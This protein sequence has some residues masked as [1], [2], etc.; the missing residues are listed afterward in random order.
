MICISGPKS[1]ALL[2]YVPDSEYEVIQPK[3]LQAS[4]WMG[5]EAG[6]SAASSDTKALAGFSSA[7]GVG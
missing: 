4:I 7:A 5:D 1:W 3:V 2:F 6:R